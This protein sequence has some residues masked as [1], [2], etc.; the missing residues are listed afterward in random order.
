MESG[1]MGGDKNAKEASC[2]AI[3]VELRQGTPGKLDF[4]RVA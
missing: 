4:D 3:L 2:S 1:R